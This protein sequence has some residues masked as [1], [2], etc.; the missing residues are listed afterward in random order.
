MRSCASLR[1]RRLLAGLAGAAALTHAGAAGAATLS[2][3]TFNVQI[4]ANGEISSLE[5]VG[6][7]FPT[8]YVLNAGNAPGQNTADHEWMGELMFTYRLGTGAWTTALTNQSADVRSV[9]S[10]PSSVTVTYANSASAKGIKNF[11][12]VETYSLTGDHLAWQIALTNTSAQSL[13]IGDL[14]LPLPWNELWTAGDIIYETRTVVHS[15]TG[16]S[17]SYITAGRP[18]GAGPFLLLTPDPTTGAGFEYMDNWRVEEHAGSAWAAGQGTPAWTNGLDVFYVHSNVIKSTNRGY[19]P[20]TSLLLAPN[21]SKT[22]AFKFFAVQSQDD[23][24]SRL[25]TEGLI[26]VT[27]VPGMML[28]TDMTAEIDLHT[29]KPIGAVTPQYPNQTVVTSLGAA[30]GDHHLYALGFARLGPNDVTVT[31]GSGETTTLQFYVLE[32]IDQAIQR[33]ATFLVNSA[34]WTSGTLKNVFDDWLFDSQSKKG[35]TGG[36]GWGDDWGWTKGE[37]LA[38]KNAQSPV[39]AEV[40]ALDAYLDAIWGTEID[41]TAFTVDDWWCPS[42]ATANCGY[43]RAF[44]YPHAYNT[45]FSMYKIAS[46]YPTLV[47]YRH[48]ADT[49]LLRAYGIL[50]ALFVNFPPTPDLDAG[51]RRNV[52]YMGEQTTPEIIAALAAAGHVTEAQN[53]T[54]VMAQ[55]YAVFKTMPYPYGSEYT[56]DNTGEEG[57]Y[58]VAR[59]NGDTTIPARIN[60]KTRA[61]RG[62][63]PTWYYYADPVTNNG[64]NW[65]QFQYTAALAGYCLDDWLRAFSTRP[66]ID[67]RL[68]YAAKIANVSA[69]NSGQIDGAPANL[70]AV[71]WGYQ[72]MKGNVYV[73]SPYVKGGETGNLHNGWRNMSGESD[74]GLFGALRILS[75]DVAVD[76][77]FGLYGYGCDVSQSGS[78]LEVTPH[79]G[80]FKRLNLVSQKLRLE[81]DRDRYTGATISGAND[82]VGFTLQNQFPVAHQTTVT[83]TGL[84]PGVYPVNVGGAPAG[85]IT[86]TS[87]TPATLTLSVGAAATYAVKIGTGCDGATTGTDAGGLARPD[88]GP[89]VGSSDGGGAGGP[90]GAGSSG[91]TAIEAGTARDGGVSDATLAGGSGGDSRESGSGGDGG[92][93]PSGPPGSARGGCGCEAA[94]AGGARGV[95]VVGSAVAGAAALA[96]R[97]RRRARG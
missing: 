5:L 91:G 29:S 41:G 33:H 97:R 49:Y 63:Q 51:A 42:I 89:L 68:T 73:G 82:Y 75:S 93:R 61:C 72:A 38:E 46:R 88:G 76:P 58:T 43:N 18:S 83:L 40:S 35:A 11:Q 87:G 3:G 12:L 74:L 57:V 27:A 45:L 4:G 30:S 24:K 86:A 2:N 95:L 56:Y 96:S 48:P 23:V 71:S 64:E 7:A 94:G 13:E 36:G 9:T 25:Y 6:D 80:V 55:R 66:E 10:T 92:D 69:I 70:G 22:Y 34:D 84:A 15:F 8:N 37:F 21:E 54:S 52:G 50:N 62:Q 60:A 19:L 79:D 67:E 65:W 77:I 85:S 20:N 16:N 90:G 26:D 1:A 17:S 39:G 31:Y 59:M 53:V 81:L 47:T 32:P 28:S 78:C 14:G 44:A